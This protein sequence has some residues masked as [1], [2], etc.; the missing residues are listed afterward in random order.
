MGKLNIDHE[1]TPV[2]PA[3]GYANIYVDQI[4]G[5]AKQQNSDGTIYDLTLG[6]VALNYKGTWNATTNTPTLSDSGGGGSEGDFY[7]IGVAGTTSIDGVSDWEI[8]DW[9]VNNGLE[10]SK[11]DNSEMVSSVFGRSGAVT[12]QSGDYNTSQVTENTNL[13]YTEGRVSANSDVAANTSHR[14]NTSNPHDVVA[15][16]VNLNLLDSPT[17]ESVQDWSNGVQSS[18]IIEGGEIT[19]GGSGTINITAIKGI[20]KTTDSD[21]GAN[22]FFDLGAQTGLSLTDCAAN[23]ISVDYNAGTPQI[24]ISL[25]NNVNDHTVFHIGKVWREGTKIEIV[26]AGLSVYDFSKRVQLYN[27]EES[28]LHMVSGASVSGTGTRNVAVTSGILYAGLNRMITDAVDTAAADNF[29]YYYYN[30]S[31][32]VGSTQT[33]IDNLQY[34]DITSGLATLTDGNYGVHWVF[35]GT[36]DNLYVVYGKGD[37]SLSEAQS[38]QPPS[39]LP[40]RITGFGA[41]RA[42]IIIAKSASSFVEVQNTSNTVFVGTSISV[43]NDL[44]G[45]Q[46]GTGSEYYHLSQA[47]YTDLTDGGA[48]GLHKHSHTNLDNIGTNTH[49]E[50]DTAISNSVSHISDTANPHSTDIGNIG[51]GTLVELNAA[52][53]DATLDD[54]SDARTPTAHNTSHEDGGGDEISVAGLSGQ[55][56]D[57]QKVAVSKNS[58]A[59]VGTRSVLNFIEGSNITLTIVDD[60]VDDE[61]DVT[62]TASGG[63]VYPSYNYDADQFLNIDP[64]G[65]DWAVDAA[66]PANIDSNNNGLI[67]RHFDDTTEEGVG[68]QFEIPAGATNIILKIKSKAQSTPGGTVAIVP[69][70]YSR[71]IGNN[72]AIG[73]WSGGTDLTAISLPTNQYF[74]YDSQTIALS[75]LGLTA[76][77]FYQLELTR[78]TGSGSD[79]LSGDWT[80][81]NV[82]VSFS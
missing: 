53:T 8:G 54:S 29:E 40:D 63:I 2:V 39:S 43:H 9:I 62:I 32:W 21:T 10:W 76:G 16:Q 57:G 31:A 3:S 36:E 15:N 61:V 51:S 56:A 26:D 44:T 25:T 17:Y 34:N 37:Y 5:R 60:A 42:K 74:Q 68:M 33:Q 72:A 45:L 38:A 52:I 70:L 18:G 1:A 48:T 69:K 73:S 58:G 79:T 82:N 24:V 20:I 6:D 66:A 12:A 46:G 65:S 75:T 50:I 7:I 78:N 41:L 67:V 49:A 80:L 27:C 28:A 55:L 81:L 47:N 14:S 59:T 71:S 4:D 23:Y 11:I 30:G 19:D 35:K 77:T 22:L 64:A 13:Y